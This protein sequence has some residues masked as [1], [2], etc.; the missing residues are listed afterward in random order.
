M[1]Y[2]NYFDSR[3]REKEKSGL[4]EYIDYK[5]TEDFLNT[6]DLEEWAYIFN[7]TPEELKIKPLDENKKSEQS[8]EWTPDEKK[9]LKEEWGGIFIDLF[10]DEE[11]EEYKQNNFNE[12]IYLILEN[13]LGFQLPIRAELIADYLI[14]IKDKT[15]S[16]CEYFILIMK[17]EDIEQLEEGAIEF[18]KKA[19]IFNVY[20]VYKDGKKEKVTVPWK[21]NY[22]GMVNSLQV[23]TVG[24]D[25]IIIE[26]G[27]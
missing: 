16:K 3:S 7:T 26:I 1:S 6:N 21:D 25:E 5:P 11:I 13:S 10:E 8:I 2:S 18:I 24:Q 9:K 15:Q 27:V 14:P 17:N 19:Q 20:Q 23:V 4:E 22:M 12:I